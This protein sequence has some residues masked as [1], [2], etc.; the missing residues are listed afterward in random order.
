MLSAIKNTD[1]NVPLTDKNVKTRNNLLILFIFGTKFYN[2]LPPWTVTSWY[3]LHDNNHKMKIRKY[4]N[5]AI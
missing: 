2:R 4:S 1:Y 3:K 5:Y